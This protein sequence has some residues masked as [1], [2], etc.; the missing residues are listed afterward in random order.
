MFGKDARQFV[1]QDFYVDDRLKSVPPSEAAFNLLKGTQNMLTHS[2]LRL[3]KIASNRREV[4]EAFPTED[5]GNGLKDLDLGLDSLPLQRSFG[6]CW[7]LKT[8]TFLFQVTEERHLS[9]TGDYCQQF[10][11]PIGI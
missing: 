8:D 4:M 5:H 1:E 10:V 6:L 2:N 7:G 9:F 3:H 11:G